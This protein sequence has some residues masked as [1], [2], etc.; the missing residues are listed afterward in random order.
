[1]ATWLFVL[2][3]ISLG[4]LLGIKLSFSL[5]SALDYADFDIGM[6]DEELIE[7]FNIWHESNPRKWVRDCE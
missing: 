6:T 7:D 2:M 1:M 5:H 3:S 4:L